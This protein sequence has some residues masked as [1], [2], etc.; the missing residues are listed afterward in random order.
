M[1]QKRLNTQENDQFKKQE[2]KIRL[3]NHEQII[4]VGQA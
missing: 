1:N 3:G 4:E 2:L